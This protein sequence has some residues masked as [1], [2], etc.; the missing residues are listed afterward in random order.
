MGQTESLETPRR[1]HQDHG[2]LLCCRTHQFLQR[3]CSSQVDPEADT[4]KIFVSTMFSNSSSVPVPSGSRKICTYRP[5]LAGA[6]WPEETLGIFFEHGGRA[7]L[8]SGARVHKSEEFS[9]GRLIAQTVV[10]ILTLNH[11]SAS[12]ANWVFKERVVKI[13]RQKHKIPQ[14]F[15]VTFVNSCVW[16][17]V[18]FD[19]DGAQAQRVLRNNDVDQIV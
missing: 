8:S 9:L 19:K 15:G 7:P 13:M 2:S 18:H 4:E 5:N 17:S 3:I 6:S 12:D 11:V 14:R 10:N 1:H 16:A